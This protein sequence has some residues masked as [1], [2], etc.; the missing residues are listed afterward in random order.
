MNMQTAKLYIKDWLAIHPYTHQ[1]AT[2]KYF[3][4]LSNRLYNICPLND[5][6]SA[7]KK[8]LCLYSAAYLEDIIS[9]LGL[10]EAF[11]TRHKELYGT[12]LPFY[13]LSPENLNEEIK[14]EDL[15]FI[16]WNTLAKAP[17]KHPYLN[18]LAP[19]IKDTARLF[20]QVLDEEYE[21]A[22]A[23]EALSGYFHHF[24]DQAEADGKL[25]WLFGHTYL[26]EPSVQEYIAQV[27]KEDQYIVPC[28]PLA[29]FL[30]EWIDLLT[31]D[32]ANNWRQVKG[33]YPPPPHLSE[34]L[35]EKNRNT[36][37]LFTQ[38]TRGASI[39]YLE[40]Y[41]SLRRFLTTTL[42][43]PDD[44]NHTLPQMKAHRNFILMANPEKGILLA[45]DVCECISDPLNPMYDPEVACREAFSLLTVPTKCPP[46]LREYLLANHYLPDAQ[47]PTWGERELVQKNADFLARHTLLYYYRGD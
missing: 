12:T 38:G 25:K 11:T 8:K 32:R 4:D 21:T 7:L 2:D 33:L 34:E 47:F 10:W 15:R 14:E 29:L 26:T 35:K 20:F 37:Q 43:W 31:N 28:G 27:T 19:A 6:P 23:N 45:N 17:D 42:Q 46:D 9:G 40:G 5:I 1:S 41:E 18:P 24:E 16:L 39:V 36:Y 3:I 44:E 13:P 22:P 30:H